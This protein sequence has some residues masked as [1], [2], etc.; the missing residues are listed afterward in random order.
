MMDRRWFSAAQGRVSG[1]RR[2]MGWAALGLG[3]AVV[4]AAAGCASD[5]LAHQQVAAYEPRVEAGERMPWHT[6]EATPEDRD[7]S[8][9][10]AAA[11]TTDAAPAN[12]E[13]RVASA[14]SRLLHREDRVTISLRGIPRS[15][16]I[17]EAVDGDGNLNLPLLGL[18]KVE[19]LT[20]AEAERLVEKGYVDQGFYQ[21]I[22]VIVVAQD[23][24]FFVRGEVI[25]PGKYPLVGDT[26]LLMAISAAGGYTDYANPRKVRVTRGD[27]VHKLNAA[28]IEARE[29]EDFL[30]HANDLIVVERRIIL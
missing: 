26:T 13:T 30:I 24:S 9:P 27:T 18:V 7:A 1:A 2:M 3:A 6:P 14:P 19:G 11:A 29:D 4:L 22:N 16:D 17:Q 12:G 23:D 15:E 20:T 5:P 10:A 21:N 8:L 28:K 25:R